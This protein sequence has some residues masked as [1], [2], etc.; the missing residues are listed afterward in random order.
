[1]EWP[2]KKRLFEF[3]NYVSVTVCDIVYSIMNLFFRWRVS[4]RCGQ[5]NGIEKFKKYIL[6][7]QWCSLFNPTFSCKRDRRGPMR[8]HNILSTGWD[9]SSV[10]TMTRPNGKSEEIELLNNLYVQWLETRPNGKCGFNRKFKDLVHL[11]KVRTKSISNL[12]G[13]INQLE[14]TI[15]M[16]FYT[17]PLVTILVAFAL[18]T[19]VVQSKP[20]ARIVGGEKSPEGAFPYFGK[21]SS[22]AHCRWRNTLRL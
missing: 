9:I 14:S 20:L 13:I 7:L 18:S 17:L 4:D 11:H 6:S 1:M 12:K 5:L 8:F 19:S 15:N 2:N 3:A 21:H 10:C 22:V 16:N